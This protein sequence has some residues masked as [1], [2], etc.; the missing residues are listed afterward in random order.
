MV[1]TFGRSNSLK[2]VPA[3]SK[4]SEAASDKYKVPE[5][6]AKRIGVDPEKEFPIK[7][8]VELAR[9]ATGY[10]ELTEEMVLMFLALLLLVATIDQWLRD[11]VGVA[12]NPLVT[13][14]ATGAALLEPKPPCSTSTATTICG[15]S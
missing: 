6:M 5:R 7:E 2:E 14:L 13:F 15:S 3:G 10:K 8:L 12:F 9:D 1:L 4:K 11:L